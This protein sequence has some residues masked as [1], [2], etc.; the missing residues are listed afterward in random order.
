MA[1]QKA[2][3]KTAGED[4]LEKMMTSIRTE[5]GD[6]AVFAG[7]AVMAADVDTIPSGSIN[8][9]RAIGVGGI[10]RGRS[11]EI[12]G[13]EA[14][15]KSTLAMSIMAQAQKM[16]LTAAYIDTEHAMVPEWAEKLGL[17]LP[18]LIIAQPESAEQ[19]LN[20]CR[21]MIKSNLVGV[22]VLDSVAAMA[23]S[24]ELEKDIGDA[25][26]ATQARMMSQALRNLCHDVFTSRTSLIFINQIRANINATGYAPKETTS[27]G[28]AL[29]FYASVRIDLRRVESVKQGEIDI[30]NRIRA[31]VVKN[32]VAPPFRT[33]EFEILFDHGIDQVGEYIDHALRQGHINRKGSHYYREEVSI[34]N[35]REMLRNN[36]KNNP[37][38][39]EALITEVTAGLNAEK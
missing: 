24:A 38:L 16:G 29:K 4:R 15:G 23:T 37:E 31:R 12:F 17:D 21:R 7:D 5:F 14:S 22:V 8:L 18:K 30:G 35:G 28:R 13:P 20:I 6:D 3:D 11:V 26:V 33:A 32:K 34:A 36:V 2:P 39:L 1:K 19:A 25:S 9:D 27:G 10:P